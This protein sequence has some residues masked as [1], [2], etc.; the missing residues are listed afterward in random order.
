MTFAGLPPELFPVAAERFTRF[1]GTQKTQPI[2]RAPE[3]VWT[4]S[5]G[6]DIPHHLPKIKPLSCGPVSLQMSSKP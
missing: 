5:F 6:V 2:N 3:D 1:D 4:K